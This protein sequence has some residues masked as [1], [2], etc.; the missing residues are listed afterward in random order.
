MRLLVA[1]RKKAVAATIDDVDYHH[2]PNKK[3]SQYDFSYEASH[4]LNASSPP[5]VTS[6]ERFKVEKGHS[7]LDMLKDIKKS[8]RRGVKYRT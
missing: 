2:K 8:G 4:N 5:I 1:T 7:M 6:K 3:I